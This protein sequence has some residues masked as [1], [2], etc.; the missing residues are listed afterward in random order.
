MPKPEQMIESGVKIKKDGSENLFTDVENIRI[1]YQPKSKRSPEKDWAGSDVIRIQAYR[2]DKVQ[3]HNL[4]PWRM[5][6]N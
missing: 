6:R 4:F 2:G 5:S 1:T 3:S